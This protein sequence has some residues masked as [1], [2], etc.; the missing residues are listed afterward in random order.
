MRQSDWILDVLYYV[1]ESGGFFFIKLYVLK[2]AKIQVK[3]I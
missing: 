3:H 1:N 2:T